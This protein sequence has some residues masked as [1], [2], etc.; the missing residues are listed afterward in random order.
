MVVV[1]TKMNNKGKF[2]ANMFRTREEFASQQLF[3]GKTAFL[4]AGMHFNEEVYCVC[5]SSIDYR[6][7]GDVE[8]FR[9]GNIVVVT[10]DP[11]DS[12][13]IANIF[14]SEEEAN[15]K[16]S[17]TVTDAYLSKQR[18][19]DELV[20]C[21]ANSIVNMRDKMNNM[22]TPCSCEEHAKVY[23]TM[24]WIRD[25]LTVNIFSNNPK[26][27]KIGALEMLMALRKKEILEISEDVLEEYLKLT[28]T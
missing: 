19:P 14:E 8:E 20:F 26:S 17:M 6:D 11:R 22:C 4:K 10:I 24:D 18:S 9:V 7:D 15:K 13:L 21:I 3:S 27:I 28:E 2:R 5:D 1:I 23:I 12:L 25:N 16:L